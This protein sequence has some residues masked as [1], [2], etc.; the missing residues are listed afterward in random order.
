LRTIWVNIKDP[1]EILNYYENFQKILKYGDA[2]CFFRLYKIYPTCAT[3]RHL[4]LEDKDETL[5]KINF[6]QVE[7]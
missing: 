2:F 1:N 6:F 4:N 3:A 7:V 5:L